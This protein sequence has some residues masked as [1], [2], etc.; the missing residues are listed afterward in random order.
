MP[1]LNGHLLDHDFHD[2]CLRTMEELACELES[3][4]YYRDNQ[5]E[6]A[7]RLA[8]L[9]HAVTCAN[10]A[11]AKD[12]TDRLYEL[13]RRET[14]AENSWSKLQDGVRLIRVKLLKVGRSR[15]ETGELFHLC[16]RL[17]DVAI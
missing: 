6:L 17:F 11:V 7:E 5:I 9:N 1:I 3:R 12:R 16:C 10:F 14:K 8:D 4:P 2:V 15:E 13:L